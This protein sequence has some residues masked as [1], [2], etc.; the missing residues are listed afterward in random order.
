MK[1]RKQEIIKTG[2]KAKYIRTKDGIYNTDNLYICEELNDKPYA[3]KNNG[4]CIYKESII[5][6]ANTI[7]ELCDVFIKKSKENDYFQVGTDSNIIFDKKFENYKKRFNNYDY[8]GAIWTDK[9]LQFVARMNSKGEL[10][11]L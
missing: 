3:T 6:Q 4:L 5:K 11:L 2:E 9:G 1:I 10:E 7:E 8:Y